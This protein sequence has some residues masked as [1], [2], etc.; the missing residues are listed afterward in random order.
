MNARLIRTDG[1]SKTKLKGGA[2]RVILGK[3]GV[4]NVAQW[5]ELPVNALTSQVMVSAMESLL[6]P[7]QLSAHAHQRDRW[8]AE[9]STLME[10]PAPGCS[11]AQPQ[12]VR[13]FGK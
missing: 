2:L 1:P 8:W 12:L 6:L 7:T 9:Y 3:K 4:G 10:L 11:L 5:V 13:A